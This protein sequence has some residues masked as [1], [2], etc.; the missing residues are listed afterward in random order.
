MT[1]CEFFGL[2][3]VSFGGFLLEG[4]EGIE[5]IGGYVRGEKGEWMGRRGTDCFD[6]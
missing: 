3:R 6:L 2:A 4:I 5:G 1:E